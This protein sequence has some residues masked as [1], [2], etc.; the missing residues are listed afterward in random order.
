MQWNL[1]LGKQTFKRKKKILPLTIK[2]SLNSDKTQPK[3]QMTKTIG[4]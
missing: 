3:T 1:S 2:F 4:K